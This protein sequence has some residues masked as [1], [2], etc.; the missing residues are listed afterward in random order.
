MAI[1]RVRARLAGLDGEQRRWSAAAGLTVAVLLAA[2][3]VPGASLPS[4]EA[5]AGGIA[6]VSDS[7]P[8]AATPGPFRV[9]APPAASPIPVG[10]G[11]WL[12][13]FSR[14]AGGDPQRLVAEAAAH[15]LTHVYLR[16]GSSTRGF[17]A[18]GD[19]D[20]LLPVAHASGLK[21][22]GWDFP[23][24]HDPG[25]DAARAAAEITYTTIGGHR[26]DAF[27]A[28]IETP[29]EGTNLSVATVTQYGRQLRFAAGPGY[30][31]IATVPRPSPK[32][33]FPYAEAVAS[34][35]AVAPMVYWGARDPV[36]DVTGAI[37]ALA[38]LGKP[39][40]PV[41][42]A[43]HSAIDGWSGGSPSK[44]AV[45]AFAQAAFDAGAVGVSFW[46]WQTA[47]PQHWAAIGEAGQFT[48]R[49]DAV[50]SGDVLAVRHLQRVLAAVGQPTVV[51]GTFGYPT[52]ASLQAF[53]RMQALP[54]TGVLDKATVR[55]LTM[56]RQSR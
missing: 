46:S 14:S 12:H 24:L 19:L 26:I 33:W 36:R 2:V 53:Q 20:R 43:Y 28:D 29:A 9:G 39:V 37:A 31:L 42:Q 25:V 40:L 48:L 45:A 49:P 3:V 55:A 13:Q 8:A 47:E 15:G 18:Q 7:A 4:A 17:Y 11:M 51:D 6:G 38:P 52:Q 10:K 34:F 54:D 16:L 22:V 56:S 44:E 50:A 23:T 27:S 21:V 41:G 5:R 32:R 35:D 30:P 1:D